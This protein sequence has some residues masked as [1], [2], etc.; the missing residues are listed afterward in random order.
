MALSTAATNAPLSQMRDLISLVYAIDPGVVDDP[1]FLRCAVMFDGVTRT[2]TPAGL[3]TLLP[4]P[5]RVA[6][7]VRDSTTG[8]RVGLIVFHNVCDA[9]LALNLPPPPPPTTYST[10]SLA[11]AGGDTRGFILDAVEDHSARAPD[12]ELLRSLVPPQ[13]LLDDAEMDVHLRCVFLRGASA[14]AAGGACGLCRVA[15]D[16][17]RADGPVRAVAAR[18]AGDAGVLVFDDA[19][20]TEV[21]VRRAPQLLHRAG[22]R[23]R[24]AALLP[25]L[26]DA[27]SREA[28]LVRR[29]L[30]PF[31]AASDYA[32]RALLLTGLDTWLCDAGEVA[33]AV[34]QRL[35][36]V[37]DRHALEA[38]A[39][40][41]AQGLVLV[42]PG[43]TDD[44]EVLLQEPPETWLTAFGRR[45]AW[46]SACGQPV[47]W[48]GP[49]RSAP[50]TFNLQ[51]R[52]G[53]WLA[54]EAYQ[55]V[56]DGL[57]EELDSL[58]DDEI[59]RISSC[60]IGSAALLQPDSV[61]HRSFPE[62][63]LLLTV[64][65][66]ATDSSDLLCEL[67]SFGRLDSLVASPSRRAA[68]AVFRSWTGAARLL[69]Q[70]S[71]WMRL[72]FRDCRPAPAT[73]HAHALADKVLQLLI[74][75]QGEQSSESD[76][77]P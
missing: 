57:H 41:R 34:Q 51:F 22:L 15:R 58:Q 8:Y 4:L 6:A 18:P 31:V 37:Y 44:V 53:P 43:S 70:P 65:G 61:R 11:S 75:A 54:T 47:L 56:R 63:A 27:A 42:V 19:A 67:S 69:R 1:D 23:M 71:T 45:V 52:L 20:D 14:S 2:T 7:L 55:H 39:V 12:R 24:D 46:V 13:Y 77:S 49:N 50:E 26:P 76:D 48:P 3:L 32:C 33:R 16:V 9:R 62:R 68:L 30:P 64:I 66:A 35:D 25:L 59:E 21:L 10:C 36:L 38:V 29:L 40:H 28:G 60:L 73:E 74:L 72:G 17:L 5:A